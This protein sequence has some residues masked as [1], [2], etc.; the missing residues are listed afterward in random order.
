MIPLDL[1]RGTIYRVQD[2]FI[3]RFLDRKTYEDSTFDP[4]YDVI[5]KIAE[6]EAIWSLYVKIG[7]KYYW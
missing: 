1:C 2:E 6:V 5:E 4:E 7:G 3:D